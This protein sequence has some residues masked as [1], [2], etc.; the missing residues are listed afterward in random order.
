MQSMS[1]ESQKKV[2]ANLNQ[3][4]RNPRVVII[5]AGFGGL[6]A[7]K[8]LECRTCQRRFRWIRLSPRNLATPPDA[9]REGRF[10]AQ[11]PETS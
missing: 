7:A 10:S 4:V 3:T 5:G 11:N 1:L 9:H 2:M 6:S 8:N